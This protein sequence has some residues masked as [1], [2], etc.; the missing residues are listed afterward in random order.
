MDK[1]EL[2]LNNLQKT[3]EGGAVQPEEVVEVVQAILG[4]IADLQR[5]LESTIEENSGLVSREHKNLRSELAGLAERITNV[6]AM[7]ADGE[8]RM[9]SDTDGVVLQIFKELKRI[10]DAIPMMP[11]LTP[12]SEKIMEVEAKIPKLP[13]EIGAEGIRDKLETLSGE[14]RLDAKAI[15]NLPEAVKKYHGGGSTGIRG[16]TSA[17]A[18]ITVDDDPTFVG[19]KRLTFAPQITVSA[20]APASPNLHDLWVD[21]S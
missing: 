7:M 19:F 3:L 6:K 20:S 14:D 18:N 5:G 4:I 17:N 21:I 2:F 15:K 13:K 10:E 1:R 12:V 8:K 9:K 11:D 16:I